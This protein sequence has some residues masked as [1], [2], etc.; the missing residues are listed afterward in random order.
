[1]E[2]RNKIWSDEVVVQIGRNGKVRVWRRK[3]TAYDPR[4][5]IPNYNN[6]K[7]SVMFWA[8]I[9]YNVRTS[10]VAVRR[11]GLDERTSPHDH[12]GMNADQYISDILEGTL[13][14]FW[15]EIHGWMADMEFMQD[16]AK[17][18]RAKKVLKWFRTRRIVLMPWPARSPD[19]NPIENCWQ[20]LKK[21]LTKRWYK[22]GRRPT[23]RD[24]LIA[25]TQEEW[26]LIPLEAINNL[27][28]SMR[29]RVHACIKA[30]GGSTKY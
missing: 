10:L 19:L 18:H 5:T 26:N 21:R 30:R 16:G 3:G 15:R 9:G 29:N 13:I 27:V 1:M 8:A 14:P 6:T 17:V 2:W 20:I 22:A 24:E 25:Q 12:G 7:F 4:Y 28:D 23:T 11:R